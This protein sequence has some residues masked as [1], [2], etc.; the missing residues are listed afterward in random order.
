MEGIFLSEGHIGCWPIG[1]SG[2]NMSVESSV[3]FPQVRKVDMAKKK[4][5]V[6]GVATKESPAAEA[7]P[8]RKKK[9]VTKLEAVR[10]TLAKMGNEAKP[11]KM[12][13]YIKKRFG[14]EMTT[15]HISTYK[16]DISRKAARLAAGENAAPGKPKV[17][18]AA[19]AKAPTEKGNGTSAV[20]LEDVLKLRDLVERV[21]PD[22][23]RTLIDV[24]SK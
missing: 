18:K 8:T 24:M 4:T 17:R 15:D 14:I 22:H 12:Q 7:A 20:M 23:L 5:S 21:G 3:L 13:G 16:G 6:A 10:R 1:Q 11:S 19:P 2:I 9:K